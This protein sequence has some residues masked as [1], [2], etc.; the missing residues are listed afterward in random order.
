ML[1]ME[2]IKG[3][4]IKVSNA[5]RCEVRGCVVEFTDG[6]TLI[7]NRRIPRYFLGMNVPGEQFVKYEHIVLVDPRRVL[8]D[9]REAYR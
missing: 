9:F 5:L 7:D 4:A 6:K 1:L 3:G 2:D 8:K